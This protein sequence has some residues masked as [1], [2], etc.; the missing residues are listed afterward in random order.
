MTPRTLDNILKGWWKQKE[1]D[2]FVQRRMAAAI[3]T[4]ITR[5]DINEADILALGK[6]TSGPEV[7]TREE[8]NEVIKKYEKVKAKDITKLVNGR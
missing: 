6:E 2:I 8:I 3:M 4:A 1:Q 5:T 7:S